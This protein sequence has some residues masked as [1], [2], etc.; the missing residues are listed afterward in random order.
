MAEDAPADRHEADAAE[1]YREEIRSGWPG[2]GWT[3]VPL[4]STVRYSRRLTKYQSC[5]EH[6]RLSSCYL[7]FIRAVGSGRGY[8]EH[9]HHSGGGVADGEVASVPEGDPLQKLDRHMMQNGCSWA[10]SMNHY[11]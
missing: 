2:Q 7:G 5:L 8:I 4:S 10:L 11:R 1:R 6:L 9:Q 3:D